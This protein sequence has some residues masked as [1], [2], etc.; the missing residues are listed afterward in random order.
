MKKRFNIKTKFGRKS[1]LFATVSILLMVLL[2][3][4][5]TSSWI[6]DVS[7]VEFKSNDDSQ[8]TPVHIGSKVL[9][10]DAVMKSNPTGTTEVNLEHYFNKSG[11]MHLS[12][13]YGDGENFYFPV[14]QQSVS[15]SVSYRTGTK[16][17]ANVNY[18]SA[19]FRIQSEGAATAYWFEKSGNDHDTPYV[20]FKDRDN[21]TA[22]NPETGEPTNYGTVSGL[23]Q[24]LRI[25]VTIDGAT[26]VYAL[27]SNGQYNT[28]SGGNTL[29]TVTGRRIDQY[30]YYTEAF[31]DNSPEQY[32]KN[33]ANVNNKPNQGAGYNLNGNTLFTVN[34]L[35]SSN[36][37]TIKTVTVKLWLEY[38]NSGVSAADLA[39]VNLNFV[40]SHAKTRRI[41]VKDA[42]VWQDNYAQ[43]KWLSHNGSSDNTAGLF[44]VLKDD[45]SVHYKLNRVSSSSDYYYVDVPA[46]YNN[47]AFKL[48]RRSSTTWNGSSEWDKWETTFPNTF[49]SET[50]T[51]YSTDFATW[52]PASN[53]HVVYFT[54]SAFFGSNHVYDYMW[55]SASVINNNDINAKVVKN[56]N[57]PGVKMNAKMKTKT[58]SQSLDT[59]AFFYNADYDRIIFNDG[60]LVTGQNQEYQTQDLWLTD[61]QGNPLNLVNGTFDMTTLTW[62]HTNPTNTSTW[63]SRMPTYS[64]A[65]ID[66][67]FST[68]NAWKKTRFAYGGEYVNTTGNAFKDTSANNMLCKVYIKSELSASNAGDYQFVIHYNGNTYKTWADN[69]HLNLYAGGSVEMYP[70]GGNNNSHVICKGLDKGVYRFYL[71]PIAN[72]GIQVYLVAGEN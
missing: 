57:W 30:T 71:K 27:N 10:S 68:N 34:K 15:N 51:V 3:I 48:S 24:Y 56:A 59:Y 60:D 14:D 54:D 26:N 50:Y 61:S 69:G 11:D 18:L 43:P 7:Q 16:D 9:K 13:C 62:F 6:E 28:V 39:S 19:T 4:S 42:T 40:S 64:T 33:T 12:P 20:T 49:H 63:S 8:Q 23:D 65:Y 46:V 38:N 31:N 66:G 45:S 41:Y 35:D 32:Y 29:S 70:E 37:N 25:S 44:W 5:G 21:V 22:T 17:D 58:A 55:D 1:I 53:V 52:E 67:N 72:N 47:A 36:A 2:T